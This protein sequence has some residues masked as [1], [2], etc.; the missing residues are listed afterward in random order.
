MDEKRLLI[1]MI[2]FIIV[3][4]TFIVT[5]LYF[6][7]QGFL[8]AMADAHESEEEK[9][10]AVISGKLCGTIAL[11]LGGLTI[12]S[13]IAIKFVPQLFHYMAILYVLALIACFAGLIFTFNKKK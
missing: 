11:A 3:G 13:G 4:V 9:R 10:H 1:I 5:G 2:A 8:Q 7:S 6:G 12:A